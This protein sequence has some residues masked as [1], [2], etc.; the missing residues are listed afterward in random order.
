MKVKELLST[1][2]RWTTECYAR[3]K[4]GKLRDPNSP[5][6]YS[7]CLLGAIR[8]CYGELTKEHVHA[9]SKI[10]DAICQLGHTGSITEFNDQIATFEDI[11]EVLEIAN[12]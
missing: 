4:N 1:R 5:R 11:Q 3:D 2:D 7:F 12:I 6:A 10:E 9:K 8:K